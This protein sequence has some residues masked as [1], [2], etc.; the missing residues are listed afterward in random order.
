VWGSGDV[1]WEIK[2]GAWYGWPDYNAGKP[3]WN[4]EEFKVPESKAVRRVLQSDPSAPPKPTAVL[5]VHASAN[6]MAF[7]K[8]DAFGFAG[9]A[10][11]AEFGDMAPKVGKVLSPVGYKIVRVNVETGVI[12]DFA[13]NKGKRNGPATWLKQGGL[14]R[15]LSVQFNPSGDALYIADFGVMEMSKRGPQ[16]KT[17]TGVIWKISKQ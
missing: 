15:P 7:S 9:D 11:V 17:G 8:S 14:E 13:V 4:D 16:P 10:F 5:G 2:P 1:L 12:R 3:I 6:G